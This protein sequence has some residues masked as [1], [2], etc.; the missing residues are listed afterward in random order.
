MD[1]QNFTKVAPKP[2]R[3]F[4]FILA[5]L[6]LIAYRSIIVLNSF[7]AFWVSF[8]WYFGTI[9]VVIYYIHRYKISKKRLGVIKQFHLDKKVELLNALGAKDK[10]AF[11]YVLES[12]EASTERWNYLLVF[13]TA[14]LALA[15][16]IILDI[17]NY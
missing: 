5:I 3:V 13:I 11:H 1:Q 17:I 16:G 6:S 9:T 4:Y 10:E 15:A 7:S 12:L 2:V 8:A 14:G